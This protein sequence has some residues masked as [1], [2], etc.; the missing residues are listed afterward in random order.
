[1][2]FDIFQLLGGLILSFGYIPQIVQIVKTK[3][4]KD[5]NLN[6]LL[7]VFVGVLFMEVYA[8]NLIVRNTAHMFFW[9]NTL[10]LMLAL[11]ML[12]LKLKYNKE[13]Q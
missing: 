8:V 5:L 2:V 7:L 12:I 10:S 3:S 11:I 4:V 1:M 9:T 13:I 6:Y